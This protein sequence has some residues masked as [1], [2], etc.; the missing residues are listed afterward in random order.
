M[1]IPPGRYATLEVRDT[2]VGMD[3]PTRARIFEPF[4]T[5]KP[6]GEG[7]GLGLATVYGIV[8]Q[9][10]GFI[11]LDSTPGIGT[12]FKIHLPLVAAAPEHQ[13]LTANMPAPVEEAKRVGE[14]I[15]LVEDEQAVRTLARRILTQRGYRVIE[16]ANGREALEIARTQ[17]DEI[18]ALVTDAVMPEMGGPELAK[19]LHAMRPGLR[20]LFMSG[21]TDDDILRRGE[22]QPG[23]AFLQKPFS[24]EQFAR[25]VR[26]IL[27]VPGSD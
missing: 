1:P 24:T 21:Y 2:G 23:A 17:L 26:D 3:A 15:L 18:D 7:S 14:T 6:V 10:G 13:E 20:T 4:F 19:Q 5:T 25:A 11:A 8:E 16:A 22:L 12:A 27:D 9:S